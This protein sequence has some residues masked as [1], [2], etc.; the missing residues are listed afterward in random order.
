MIFRIETSKAAKITAVF[1]SRNIRVFSDFL[2]SFV[3]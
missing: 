2:W 3:R 1:V